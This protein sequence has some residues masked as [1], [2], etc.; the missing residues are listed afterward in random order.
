MHVHTKAG[1]SATRI[2][3]LAAALSL[4][5]LLP[6]S[7]QTHTY[8]LNNTYADFNGGPSLT[9][10]GGTLS[11]AGYAFA[12]NQGLSLSNVLSGSDYS[13]EMTF[14]LSDVTGYR[15]LLDFQDLASDDGLYLLNGHLNFYPVET[16]PTLFAANQS[17][18]VD[19]TRDGTTQL[20]TG[21]VN[22]TQEFS[23]T[24]SSN[25]AVFS[26]PGGLIHFFEDDNV[27][28]KHE[29]S[30]GTVTRITIDGMSSPVPEASTNASFGL[31]L[32]GLGGVA[33]SLRRKA[34]RD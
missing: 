21:S 18:T 29:A 8:T 5:A 34:A 20:V 4:A 7:A 25:R 33:F 14:S 10:D 15:K 23:F 12:A 17:I 32:L 2:L 3:G 16:G 27:T 11:A 28:S 1:A 24:D 22:G 31:F 19:L 30:G 26:A 9:P 6:A 13:I